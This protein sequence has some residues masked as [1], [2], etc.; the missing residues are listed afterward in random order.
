MNVP[1]DGP[2]WV[3]ACPAAFALCDLLLE[4]RERYNLPPVTSEQPPSAA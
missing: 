2:I 4:L 3:P 1:A